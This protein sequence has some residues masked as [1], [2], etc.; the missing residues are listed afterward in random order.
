[1]ICYSHM[2]KHLP[3]SLTVYGLSKKELYDKD[4]EVTLQT[5][6]QLAWD[7][8]T[9]MQRVQPQGPYRLLGWSNGGVISLAITERLKQQG[10]KVDYLGLID[11]VWKAKPKDVLYQE[12]QPV[13]PQFTAL[14]EYMDWLSQDTELVSDFDH[15]YDVQNL[16]VMTQNTVERIRQIIVSGIIGLNNYTLRRTQQVDNVQYFTASLSPHPLKQQCE[17][18]LK[19]IAA[20]R[21][22]HYNFKTDHHSIVKSDSG[23]CIAESVGQ[24]L[25][26]L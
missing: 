17:F 7:Y 22:E 19:E 5:M 8:V 26:S 9:Q 12:L 15:A 11:S 1:V 25:L 2:L 20:E 24:V 10:N 14:T 6:E 3:P 16:A 4:S 21:F 13:L 23:K 18:L